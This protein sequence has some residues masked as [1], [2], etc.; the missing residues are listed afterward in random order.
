[1]DLSKI[2]S[3]KDAGDHFLVDHASHGAFKVSKKGLSQEALT[4]IKG[5]QHFDEGSGGVPGDTNGDIDLV[6]E[7]PA[8]IP[9]EKEAPA[10]GSA[11][12]A[13]AASPNITGANLA[14]ETPPELDPWL[15][16][17][18]AA[19]TLRNTAAPSAPSAVGTGVIVPQGE[20]ATNLL[21]PSSYAPAALPGPGTWDAHRPGSVMDQVA[22]VLSGG[23]QNSTTSDQGVGR[24]PI[25]PSKLSPQVAAP[26]PAPAPQVV[27]APVPAPA[28]QVAAP[29]PAPVVPSALPATA[30]PHTPLTAIADKLKEILPK[31]AS[32]DTPGQ[33]AKS[34][35]K[36][37]DDALSKDYSAKEAK[38][39]DTDLVTR[40]RPED[41]FGRGNSEQQQQFRQDTTNVGSQN[42]RD[43]TAFVQALMDKNA[44]GHPLS[45][46][47]ELRERLAA[48]EKRVKGSES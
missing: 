15:V 6:P 20:T 12:G 23:Q 4:K 45:R 2:K 42:A 22:N 13:T 30:A 31:L 14:D 10:I 9:L 44:T 18:N 17:Q 7:L 43:A 24:I 33:T 27:A 39:R 11:T 3:V 1:M 8:S 35:G 25:D 32:K 5:V 40:A 29:A 19:G 48:L 38:Q 28:P 47:A 26:A 37:L 21:P 41:S 16:Q 46:V 36:Q 34:I